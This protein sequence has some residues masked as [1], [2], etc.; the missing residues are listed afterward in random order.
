MRVLNRESDRGYSHSLRD[1]LDTIPAGLYD[2][3]ENAIT[4]CGT[5]DRQYLLPNLLCILFARYPLTP[6][7]LYQALLCTEAEMIDTRVA[8]NNPSS[9]QVEKFILNTSK[10]LAEISGPLDNPAACRVQFIHGTVRQFLKTSGLGRLQGSMCSNPKGISHDHLRARCFAYLSFVARNTD[11]SEKFVGLSCR[12]CSPLEPSRSNLQGV[13]LF[14][15]RARRSNGV[16]R[17]G[18]S[19]RHLANILSGNVPS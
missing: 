8:E 17:I 4:E 5:S 9:I 18:T 13:S 16:R 14:E 1:H 3:F 11:Q 6:L 12:P 7:A 2:V 10:G 15:K 19:L